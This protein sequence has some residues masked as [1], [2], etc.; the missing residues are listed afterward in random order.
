MH[1]FKKVIG[2]ALALG[3]ANCAEPGPTKAE[4]E[5]ERAHDAL[6]STRDRAYQRLHNC[7]IRAQWGKKPGTIEAI[8]AS[9]SECKKEQD[10]FS[11]ASDNLQNW[12]I[13]GE[14]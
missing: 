9:P 6:V 12:K 2:A 14:N 11:N 3:V 5:W 4:Q 10:A 1:E 7:N 8:Y 13:R